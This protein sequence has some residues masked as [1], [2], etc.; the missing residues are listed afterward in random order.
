MNPIWIPALGAADRGVGY[1][2]LDADADPA[3]RYEYTIQAITELGLTSHS[4]TLTD[5]RN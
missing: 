5:S 2:F 3:V 1:R 4:G